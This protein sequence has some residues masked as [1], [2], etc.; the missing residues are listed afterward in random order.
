MALTSPQTTY[1]NDL[2]ED[3]WGSIRPLLPNDKPKGRRR[4]TSLR[5]VVSAISYRDRVGCPWRML[6][7]DFPAWGTVY[8]YYRR[9]NRAGILAEIRQILAMG[10]ESEAVVSER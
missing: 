7:E 5:E 8:S 1:P 10:Q 9:W 6:P 2:T 4:A 3:Q